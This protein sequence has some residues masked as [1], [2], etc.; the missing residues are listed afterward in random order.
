MATL[1]TSMSFDYLNIPEIR[2]DEQR[3]QVDA[4]TFQMTDGFLTYTVTAT[5]DTN[6]QALT[7]DQF[8]NLSGMVGTLQ[9]SYGDTPYVTIDGLNY[10]I[11]NNYYDMGYTV[12]GVTLYAVTGEVAAALQGHDVITGSAYS[13]RLAGF[14]GNDTLSGNGGADKLEGWSGNDQLNGGAG[15]DTLNGGGG[16]DSLDGGS[17]LDILAGKGGQDTLT[18]GL[19][20]DKFVFDTALGA[21]N[22]DT[23]TDF[24]VSGADKILLDDDI[25]SRLGV[26]GTAAGVTLAAGRLQ[27]GTVALEANDRIIYD[28]TSGALY[29]DS[30]GTGVAAQVQFAILG[31]DVHPSVVAADFL[32]IA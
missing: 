26:T 21:T 7:A 14:A 9:V 20:A 32:V 3:S 18:G 4:T 17:G 6:D 25:F 8:G 12:D 11:D 5:A 30:D 28:Q 19:N 10:Q 13:D 27:L 16:L 15:N 1:T 2:A 22:V 23:I 29:Y 31:T 24:K